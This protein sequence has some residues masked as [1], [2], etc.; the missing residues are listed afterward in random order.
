MEDQGFFSG[1]ASGLG[2]G[3]RGAGAILSPQVYQQQNKEQES[4][5]D[6]QRRQKELIM[7]QV[8]TAM[9]DGSMPKEQGMEMLKKIGVP[10]LPIGLDGGFTADNSRASALDGDLAV[11]RRRQNSQR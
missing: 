5:M 8:I 11:S 9:R 3:L 1:L 4:L 2:Q 10:A 7:T 6:S